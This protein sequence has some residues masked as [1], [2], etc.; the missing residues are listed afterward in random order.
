VRQEKRGGRG[1]AR[2]RRSKEVKENKWDREDIDEVR[3]RE[4]GGCGGK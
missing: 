4:L 1:I 3:E 2:E